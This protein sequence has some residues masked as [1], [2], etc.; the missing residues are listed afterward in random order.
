[1]LEGD[2]F[3]AMQFTLIIFNLFFCRKITS[4]FRRLFVLVLTLIA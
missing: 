4:K 1:M 2:I 3:E